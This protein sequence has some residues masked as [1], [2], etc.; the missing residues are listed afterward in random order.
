MDRDAKVEAL[1]VPYYQKALD[2]L[3]ELDEELAKLRRDNDV[4]PDATTAD[5]DKRILFENA[6]D[7]AT[8]QLN[9]ASDAIRDSLEALI[10]W[11]DG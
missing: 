1:S 6:L 8:D 11:D 2:L 9:T 7:A 3:I 10:N 5:E 4:S